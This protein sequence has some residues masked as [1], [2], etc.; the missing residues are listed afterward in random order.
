MTMARQTWRAKQLLRR[1]PVLAARAGQTPD[2]VRRR[3]PR[4]PAGQFAPEPSST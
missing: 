1:E 2:R 3:L 4:D